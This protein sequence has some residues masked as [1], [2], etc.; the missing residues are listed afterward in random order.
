MKIHALSETDSEIEQAL[1][2]M[3]VVE[4]WYKYDYG[5]YEGSGYLVYK[6]DDGWGYKDLGH[7]SCYGPMEGGIDARFGTYEELK[8]YL[9]HDEADDIF[10]MIEEDSLSKED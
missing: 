7:C 10:K 9:L 4:A 1:G 8:E 5:C 2:N 3:G 6:Q